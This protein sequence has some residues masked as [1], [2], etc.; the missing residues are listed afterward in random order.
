VVDPKRHRQS[1][2]TILP[3]LHSGCP[4]SSEEGRV[5]LLPSSLYLTSYPLPAHPHLSLLS[6]LSLLSP[7][8]PGTARRAG[9]VATAPPAARLPAVPHI[10]LARTHRLGRDGARRVAEG[11]AADL[12]R[13]Y[14]L[15]WAWEGDALRFDG[16][17]V[18]GV[19]TASEDAVR[20][21]A[22]LALAARPFRRA[23]EAEIARELDRHTAPA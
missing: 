12:A 20:V 1:D 7:T 11:V 21:T 15:R 2:H 22:D 19:L 3:S 9:R 5:F 14:G 8:L 10:E 23:L 13:R 18:S 16:R 4:S 6:L 17:G